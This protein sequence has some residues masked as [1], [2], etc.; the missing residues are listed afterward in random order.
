MIHPQ[1]NNTKKK[2]KNPKKL[3]EVISHYSLVIGFK[4]NE[5]KI[6]SFLH[7]SH[8]IVKLKIYQKTIYSIIKKV[9]VEIVKNKTKQQKPKQQSNK[10]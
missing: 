9:L 4:I 10:N 3:L 8:E 6:N 1:I 5:Q 2:K 7:S